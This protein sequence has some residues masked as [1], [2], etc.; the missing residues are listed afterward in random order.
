MSTFHV[1]DRTWGMMC[2]VDELK[3]LVLKLYW[4]KVFLSSLFDNV[5]REGGQWTRRFEG[6]VLCAYSRQPK[7]YW[8]DLKTRRCVVQ[9]R[10]FARF[11][12]PEVA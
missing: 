9:R 3:Q 8:L 11:K 10:S 6:P 5:V 2:G 1:C 7:C 12:G 4:Q